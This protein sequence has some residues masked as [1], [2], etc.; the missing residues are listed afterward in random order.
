VTRTTPPA[1][2]PGDTSAVIPDFGTAV[3][4]RTALSNAAAVFSPP[5]AP[6]ASETSGQSAAS[7]SVMTLPDHTLCPH[8]ATPAGS[9]AALRSRP[10]IDTGPS[11]VQRLGP[12][13][14][15]GSTTSSSRHP[16][17]HGRHRRRR[18]HRTRERGVAVDDGRLTHVGRGRRPRRPE[19]VDAR[20]AI[21]IPGLV[22]AHCHAADS[23]FR[24]LVEDLPLEPWLQTVWK[25]EAAILTPETC[26]SARRSA[27]PNSRS[28]ASPPPSTCSG[29]RRRP[30]PPPARS[31]CASPRAAS[32]S[33]DRAPTRATRR[34]PAEA[35]AFFAAHAGADDVIPGTFPHGAYTVGPDSAAHRQGDRRPP[36]RALPHPRR[37]DR[38]RAGDRHR[39]LRPL[40]DPPPRSPR[41]ARR[42]H[43]AR[44]L[45]LARRRGDRHPRPHRRRGRAQPGLEPQ[46]RLRHRPHPRPPG[47]RRAPSPSAPTARSRAT[48]S[49]SG[50]RCA[51]P[52]P[53]TR[54]RPAGPTR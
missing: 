41:P 42:P 43:R 37:R 29:T 27:S 9:I 28:A 21:L 47:R 11:P 50:W 33:T 18:R 20:G 51:S 32:S 5:V 2:A 52:R 48:T 13:P 49:T 8:R 14:R 39:P 4:A 26:A 24:G 44:P 1:A 53:C 10:L 34:R 54:A 19:T 35:E 6:A 15:G 3:P 45:R 30:S 7:S 38:G 22:N 36:R 16:Q 25:A 17:R 40:G 31:A 46:A 23:L 12:A